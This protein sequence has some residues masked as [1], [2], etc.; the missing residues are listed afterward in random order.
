M[1][2]L[3]LVMTLLLI[4]IFAKGEDIVWYTNF[5]EA[6][7]K[8]KEEGKPI[9]ML[10]TGSDWCGWC[11]KL[12]GEVLDQKEFENRM[13]DQM[14]FVKLDFPMKTKLPELLRKQN[15]EL[16]D[17]FQIR[18]YPTVILVDPELHQIGQVGYRPGGAKAYAEFLLN[19]IGN[20]QSFNETMN[21][22][23]EKEF[24]SNELQELYKKAE[25]FQQQ[26]AMAA[27]MAAGMKSTENLFFLTEKFKNLVESGDQNSPE[28]ES[29]RARLIEVSETAEQGKFTVA[30][31][32]FQYL[33]DEMEIEGLENPNRA[34]SPLLGY[35]STVEGKEDE[36]L[37]KAH[38]LASKVYLSRDYYDEA[39]EHSKKSLSYAP[40]EMKGEIEK[41]ILYIGQLKDLEEQKEQVR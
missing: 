10:F 21:K 18:G 23:G 32:E 11:K 9:F 5:K 24:S 22:F 27:V 26:P 7:T 6:Q 25:A 38:I 35:I 19:S 39:L 29:V 40:D 13:A 28:G 4:P 41:A 3:L 31:I 12:E 14:I 17:K 2:K 15:E 34:V 33:R 8:A 20:R 30:Q 37:W 16:R 36:N 1:R